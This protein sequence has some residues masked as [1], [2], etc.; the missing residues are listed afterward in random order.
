MEMHTVYFKELEK[1]DKYNSVLLSYM[2]KSG[3]M[4][5]EEIAKDSPVP[6]MDITYTYIHILL[7]QT[8]FLME[9]YKCL[10]M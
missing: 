4:V 5:P 9:H 8:K 6:L 3:I 7:N 2:D 1:K 10:I